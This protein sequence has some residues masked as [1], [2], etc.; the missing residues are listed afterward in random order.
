MEKEKD[1]SK[2]KTEKS[3]GAI[4]RNRKGKYL[5][6]HYPERPPRSRERYWGLVKGHIEEGEKELETVKRETE[7]ETGIDDLEIVDGFKEEISYT[8]QTEKDKIFKDV[9][10]YLAKTK[11]EDIKLSREHI[12]Y[13]WAGFKEAVET[14]TYKES[15]EILK[16]AENFK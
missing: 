13:K 2:T 15:K 10:F 4:I 9:I 6:L 11:T 1:F 3:A 5:L 12:G 14:L 7:E 8:F 16:K